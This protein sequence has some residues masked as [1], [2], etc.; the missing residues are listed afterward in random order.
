MN[1]SQKEGVLFMY[2]AISYTEV[3]IEVFKEICINYVVSLF[4]KIILLL[5]PSFF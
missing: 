1:K 4:S 3:A 5:F 2:L